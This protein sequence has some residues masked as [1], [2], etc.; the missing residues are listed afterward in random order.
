MTPTDSSSSHT[1]LSKLFHHNK[2]NSLRDTLASS[3]GS[4]PQQAPHAPLGPRRT[5]SM[6]SLK[7]RNTNPINTNI[8]TN[9]NRSRS[10]SEARNNQNQLH[11]PQPNPTG[12][13]TGVGA[14]TGTGTGSATA[15]P[16]RLKL[17]KAET[18]AHLQQLDT[19]N[20]AKQQLR[21]HRIPSHH[22]NGTASPSSNAT[23]ALPNHEKIVYN[24]YGINKS[25]SQ[26]LPKH[27]SFYLSGG[28]DA[29]RVVANPV[30]D[31]N[32]YL[33]EDLRQKHI[34]LIDEFEIDVNKKHL[35]DGGS[36]DVRIINAAHS[37][38]NLFALKKFTLL[39]KET[40]DDFYK[41][42]VKEYVIHK[43][44]AA[45]RHVVDVFALL[46][47]Q[48][49][50]NLTRGWGVVMEFCGGGDLFSLIIRPGWKLSP[51]AEKYCIFKQIAYGVRYLHEQDIAHR[52][53]KPENVL[54][55]ANGVAKLCDFGVSDY[56]HTIPG[57]YSSALKLSSSYVGSPP[58]SPPEVMILKDMTHTEAKSH[59]YNMFEMDC[60][61][62]GMLLFCLVYSGVPFQQ[63]SVTDHQYRE[64][65]FSHKRFSSDHPNFK[66]NRGFM[67]GPGSDFKL[68]AK[69]ESTG[70]SRVAWKLCD[71]TA[72][73]R[74]T[75]DQ[76]M[77]DTWFKALEM[78]IYED[79][80]QS[81]NPFVLPGTGENV[82]TY[83]ALGS[84][85]ANTSRAPSRR[86]TFINR[87]HQN[88]GGASV[89]GH[90]SSCDEANMSGSFKSMLDL[91]V[92]S[93]K[94]KEHG[95]G[96][97]TTAA[98]AAANGKRPMASSS[99]NSVHSSDGNAT[100]RTRSMLDVVG[101]GS[102]NVSVPPS[103]KLNQQQQQQ[104]V[105]SSGNLPAL[106]ES[107]IEHDPHCDNLSVSKQDDSFDQSRDSIPPS[108]SSLTHAS[109]ENDVHSSFKL[110]PAAD[111]ERSRTPSQDS[112]NREGED[113][114]SAVNQDRSVYAD[115]DIKPKILK[116]LSDLKLEADGTC[117]LGYKLKKH[118]HC[119]VSNVA[120]KGL[121]R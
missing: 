29:E 21:N 73:S 37:K 95:V 94:I 104:H 22:Q 115:T 50:G 36:S 16:L 120:N 32:N 42:V 77:E 112:E 107:D 60:W 90:E 99:N 52:D 7:R 49:Q 70:A 117:P 10:S 43:R 31:P 105:P 6:F 68:A 100:P 103:P 119:E 9:G 14:G 116:S 91:N 25:T 98:A 61:S 62:L 78:C 118:H 101:V 93:E 57:D 39:H 23:P 88:I 3:S 12:T 56:G 108:P 34:N 96:V 24:P 27:A 26:D 30:A 44:A 114:A 45:S 102:E 79:P 81:V 65:Q 2:D 54:L 58:Y 55:D 92:V 80:D 13:G 20:A 74:Y 66:H 11:H 110:P 17:S 38:K 71:P 28:H 67:K 82:H 87:S 18:F 83:P 47:I 109:I 8:A 113:V 19:R 4:S 53:L 40:D 64:Y 97:G 59:A 121:R 35:G 85:S 72:S 89:D 15:T 86:G 48:S 46:R 111:N 106:E 1:G 84:S 63:S 51:L 33:P 41:R 69:F 75:M 5:P 76:L